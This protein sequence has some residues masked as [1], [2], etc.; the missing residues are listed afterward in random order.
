M[1]KS[2]ALVF[3]GYEDV[4]YDVISGGEP[5]T[6]AVRLTGGKCAMIQPSM[7]ILKTQYGHYCTGE[8][9]MM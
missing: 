8:P 3:I 7:L 4:N 1:E 2:K 5:I 9:S 6:M